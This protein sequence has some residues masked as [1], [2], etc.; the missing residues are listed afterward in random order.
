VDRET[1]RR[2]PVAVAA[3]QAAMEALQ[4]QEHPCC[5]FCGKGNPIGFKL[6]FRVD[7]P[8]SVRA[9]LMCGHRFRSY[10]NTLHGGVI[11]ALLD[12]TMT[13]ALFS[14][15]V[16]AV[17]GE[18]TVRFLNPVE[19]GREAEVFAE[20]VQESRPLYKL[21]ARLTQGGKPVAQATAKFVDREWAT[22]EAKGGAASW[23]K[24]RGR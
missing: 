18:L 2:D 22:S 20:I 14:L 8:G 17:T 11:S 9:A 15:N 23:A 1:A 7:K 13:N 5:L 3:A 16:V 6:D 4:A 21:R 12:A 24:Y 10:S 19:L